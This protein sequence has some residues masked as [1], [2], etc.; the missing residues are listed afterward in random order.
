MISY[1]RRISTISRSRLLYSPDS[2][3]LI[4]FLSLFCKNTVL[5]SLY[6]L[7]RHFIQQ[8]VQLLRRGSLDRDIDLSFIVFLILCFNSSLRAFP[9]STVNSPFFTISSSTSF[10]FSVVTAT[11]P[12]PASS[13]F[14]C[15][16]QNFPL[17]SLLSTQSDIFRFPI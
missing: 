13:I 15:H 8:L 11:A 10:D 6:L 12:I 16:L 2:F 3:L 14:S 7:R 5:Q 1:F 9:C 4:G 17:S